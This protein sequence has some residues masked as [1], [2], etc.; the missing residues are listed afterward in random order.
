MI[1][2]NINEKV[3]NLFADRSKN[4]SGTTLEKGS[5]L[6]IQ[7]QETKIGEYATMEKSDYIH[8]NLQ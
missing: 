1:P 7:D 5:L 8:T 2:E 4:Q 3:D 6:T